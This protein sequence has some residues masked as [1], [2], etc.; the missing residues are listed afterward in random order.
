MP[1]FDTSSLGI[2]I[3]L[4]SI[5]RVGQLLEDYP[6]R[7]KN[8]AFTSHEQQYCD[9]QL[10]PPQHYASRWAVKESFIKAIESPEA[11]PDFTSIE[12]LHEPT[13]QLSLSE[14]GLDLLLGKVSKTAS[15]MEDVDLSVS[16]A[17][18]QKANIALGV[19]III[20]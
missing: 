1:S 17:H 4:V 16:M 7:F 14:D 20:L 6:N 9:D 8:L 5:S 19:V 2:G 11:N 15:E 13:P 3:D 10:F 12:I 18:E